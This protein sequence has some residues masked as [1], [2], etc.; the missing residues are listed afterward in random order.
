MKG[1]GRAALLSDAE[2]KNNHVASEQRR[3][4]S[5]RD[6]LLQ[7]VD[8]VPSLAAA[9]E[10]S[11]SSY[12]TAAT[13]AAAAAAAAA[14]PGLSEAVVLQ[15]T[16]EH[17]HILLRQQQE[18]LMRIESARLTLGEGA[19]EDSDCSDGEKDED[20]DP[21][22]SRPMADGGEAEALRRHAQ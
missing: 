8:V 19:D 1:G 14:S 4:Q 22:D 7:L 3:R 15:K 17:I 10:S 6:A 2:K 13:A 11:S 18:L 16:I 12:S 21:V 20:R 9:N 5:I